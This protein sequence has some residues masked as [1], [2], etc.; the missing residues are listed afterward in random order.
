MI[1]DLISVIVPIYNIERYVGICIE[2]IINQTY[3]NLEIIL[4][5][6]GSTDRSSAICDLYAAKDNRIKVI[7]KPN[8]GLVSARKSG[9]KIATGRFIGYVDGD[10][11][12][13][14][15]FYESL[16]SDI[17]K[18]DADIAIAGYSRDLFNQ[19]VHI[20]SN[21]ESGIYDGEG[22][23]DLLN[24]YIS[25][26]D[27]YKNGI[28]TYLWNKLFKKD[29]LLKF[30][31]TVCDDISIGED[32]AVVYPLLANCHRVVINDKCEYHYRQREDSMLKT[33]NPFS[34]EAVGLKKL[35]D[36]LTNHLG[37]KRAQI[38]DFIL[39]QCIIRSGAIVDGYCLYEK[40]FRDKNVIVFSAGTF[41]QQLVK[42]IAEKNYCNTVGWV[43]D[44]YWEYRRCCLNVDGVDTVVGAKYDHIILATVDGSQARAY[45]KR[46]TDMGVPPAKILSVACSKCDKKS[47]IDK[48]LSGACNA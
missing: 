30:Q 17:I 4:V 22:L 19:T 7:H 12:I 46:L 31:S 21:I 5:D 6:D 23:R 14:P 41:G 26:G 44:D 13:E 48:Y 3:K 24:K 8:G 11:Y 42:R 2:S 43:D 35:Y 9:V 38:E 16:I 10:D 36:Y 18:C 27:F 37:E 15:T 1:K 33:S 28:N 40:D 25:Y 45:K 29:I 39:A 34:V 20:A 32:A 47:V